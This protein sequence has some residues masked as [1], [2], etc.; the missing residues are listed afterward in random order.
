MAKYQ[1]VLPL[2]LSQ[3]PSLCAS[4]SNPLMC[5]VGMSPASAS[6]LQDTSPMDTGLQV[7][8]GTRAPLAS[9]ETIIRAQIAKTLQSAKQSSTDSSNAPNKGGPVPCPS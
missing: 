4:F 5:H 3:D 9:K 8:A 2:A 1:N 6:I 7:A